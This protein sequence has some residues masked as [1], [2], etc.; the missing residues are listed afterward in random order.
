MSQWDVL[1]AL[2]YRRRKPGVDDAVGIDDVVRL[3]R[4]HTDWDAPK[5]AV[6]DALK[7][8]IDFGY[9]AV[10]LRVEQSRGRQYTKE[11]YKA[12]T[13]EE[14]VTWQTTV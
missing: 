13:K 3:T 1:D 9:V 10:E 5:T 12:I 14:E 11:Y 6:Y 8:L 4:S 7:R 2:E